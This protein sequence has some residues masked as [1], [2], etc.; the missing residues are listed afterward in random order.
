MINGVYT[1]Q[2]VLTLTLQAKDKDVGAN[3][4]YLVVH[5]PEMFKI[6]IFVQEPAQAAKTTQTT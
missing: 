1:N 3:P 5:A 2:Q 6:P 4:S